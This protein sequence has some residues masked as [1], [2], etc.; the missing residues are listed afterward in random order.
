MAKYYR[1][2]IEIGDLLVNP[3]NKRYIESVEDELEAIIAM[4]DVVNGNPMEEMVALA[5]DISENGL[6]PFEQPIVWFDLESEKYVVVEGNRRI[7][8]IKMMTTYRNN[9]DIFRA[10]P[11]QAKVIFALN[12]KFENDIECV[13]Y[14]ELEDANAVLSKIHQDVNGGL[15]R[16]QWTPQAKEKDK[17]E[18]GNKSKMYALVEF[19]KNHPD[20]EKELLNKMNSTQWISKLERVVGFSK[21]RDVYNITFDGDNNILYK[22]TTEHV[23]KML[24]RLIHDLIAKTATGNFRLK[25]D[26]ENYIANLSAEFKTQVDFRPNG[27]QKSEKGVGKN[28][29][30]SILSDDENGESK[31]ENDSF[32]E[33]SLPS[34]K[35]KAKQ[36]KN[37]QEALGLSKNYLTKEKECL[38]EKGLDIL[39]ELESLDVAAYPYASAALCRAIIEYTLNLW[40]EHFGETMPQNGLLGAY[41]KVI[42]ILHNK[43]VTDGKLNSTLQGVTKKENFIGNLNY[44][45]HSHPLQCVRIETLKNGWIA[46]RIIVEL[47]IKQKNVSS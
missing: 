12:Y 2:R 35:R 3:D 9:E 46:C 32:N 11:E 47:Y 36:K 4:F 27:E 5:I 1:K 19:V 15:G 28:R 37:E 40:C 21:F 22:D 34:P 20:A 6:N 33:N 17:A 23:Y 31:S 24:A 42:A 38:R 43:K 18:L 25:H 10:I 8:C 41:K 29:S 44:W 7:I 14:D 26:F 16:K 39:N 45:M 13:V 30:D